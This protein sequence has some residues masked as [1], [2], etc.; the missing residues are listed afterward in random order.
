[1]KHKLLKKTSN[2][3][4]MFENLNANSKYIPVYGLVCHKSLVAEWFNEPLTG[5]RKVIGFIPVED[6]DV[7]LCPTLVTSLFMLW[8]PAV[9][10][11][12]YIILFF[13]LYF[14]LY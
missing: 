13:F 2:F 6:S 1:M 12:T 9:E 5:V 10:F 3:S 14:T 11:K 4:R 8:K 7:F